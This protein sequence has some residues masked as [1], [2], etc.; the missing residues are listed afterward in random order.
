MYTLP[1][2]NYELDGLEPYIDKETMSLHYGKH[3][4]TYCDK[5]NGALEKYPE[6]AEKPAEDLLKDLSALP[7][8]IKKAV[9][10]FG[11]GFVNHNF[12]W[13]ILAPAKDGKNLPIGTLAQKITEQFGS[14]TDFKKQLSDKAIG[15]FGSGWAWLVVNKE[16][17]LEIISTPNQDSPLSIG[18]KPLITIDVWE[19]AYYLKYQ[20]R[21]AEFVEAIWAIFDWAKVEENYKAGF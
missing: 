6:L 15:V 20:N 1:K 5:L 2:L 7:E 21:R 9:Q 3:H 13:S 11:G 19:H 14:F 18:Q 16:G 8:E 17:N 12:F 4:Q 10:N